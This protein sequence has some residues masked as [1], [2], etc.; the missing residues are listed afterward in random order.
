MSTRYKLNIEDPNQS[1][2][3]T[4]D[5][6]QNDVLLKGNLGHTLYPFQIPDCIYCIQTENNEKNE[7]DKKNKE[8]NIFENLNNHAKK[9][10]CQDIF[11]GSEDPNFN[12]IKDYELNIL[13]K[14]FSSKFDPNNNSTIY[15]NTKY[16]KF[17]LDAKELDKI[18]NKNDESIELLKQ[19]ITLNTDKIIQ[20]KELFKINNLSIL[21]IGKKGVGKTSLIQY[22]LKD[23][24]I[25]NEKSN[26]IIIYKNEKTYLRLIEF[27]PMENG[28]DNSE[29]L[30]KEVLNYITENDNNN[31]FNKYINCI[32]YCITDNRFNKTEIDLLKKLSESF[33]NKNIPIIVIYTKAIDTIMADEILKYIDNL[34]IGVSTI[35]LNAE[36]D[37]D[38]EE[39]NISD[40]GRENLL[41]LTLEKCSKAIH[42]K[43]IQRMFKEIS[44]YIIKIIIEKINNNKLEMLKKIIN[45]FINYYNKYFGVADFENYLLNIL[46]CDLFYLFDIYHDENKMIKLAQTF[47]ILEKANLFTSLVNNYEKFY[48]KQLE[49]SIEVVIKEYAKN[50][51]DNQAKIEIENG[52]VKIENKRAL[53]DMENY[54]GLFFKKNFYFLFQKIITKNFIIHNNDIYDDLQK[55]FEEIIKKLMSNDKAVKYQLYNC[56]L[57]KL[58]HFAED[59]SIDF[60]IDFKNNQRFYSAK[61]NKSEITNK[62]KINISKS[63]NLLFIPYPNTEDDLKKLLKEEINSINFLNLLIKTE[64]AIKYEEKL[65]EFMNNFIFQMENECFPE[66]NDDQVYSSLMKL[67]KENLINYFYSNI[68]NLI[69]K[70]KQQFE[71]NINKEKN[72]ETDIK[73]IINNSDFF[74]KTM[75][76]AIEKLKT[77]KR[78]TIN[79]LTVILVGE[80]GVGK[81]TLINAIFLEDVAKTGVVE[82]VTKEMHIVEVIK[83]IIIEILK[84]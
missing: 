28:Q 40:F 27:D 44:G 72:T 11:Q 75:I 66:H 6:T 84:Y 61:K 14:Y 79:Y 36:K 51:L 7:D 63:D 65:N 83:K 46:K 69:L 41:K 58:K 59:N 42:G 47:D 2:T 8:D 37:R 18:F 74:S 34:K 54:I 1:R 32:W 31:N 77:D 5:E 55:F 35:K 23:K 50:F 57:M 56:F 73:E 16:L 20:N 53:K 52:N 71:D 80:T 12:K 60:K 30:Q 10:V 81:S 76:E 29:A 24:I 15:S 43:M 68:N 78:N 62:N 17:T 64:K 21:I 26:N 38:N 67:Y 25:Y 22:I 48:K 19:M 39:Q 3:N 33:N 13:K 45:D 82:I 4:I 49:K 70:I 9:I